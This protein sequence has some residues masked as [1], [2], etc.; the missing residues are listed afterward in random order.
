ML[1][2]G[3]AVVTGLADGRVRIGAE[4]RTVRTVDADEPKLTDRLGERFWV[5]ARI[6]G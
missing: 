6:F 2:H 3:I 4:D 1:Q 5:V